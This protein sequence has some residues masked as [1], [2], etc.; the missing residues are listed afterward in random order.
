M[1][2]A[3]TS[4]TYPP[5]EAALA[6]LAFLRDELPLGG[7][8]AEARFLRLFPL[9]VS[10]IVGELNAADQYR[11]EPGGWLGRKERWSSYGSG[12]G[13]GA[14]RGST[15]RSP[16]GLRGSSVGGGIGGSSASGRPAGVSRTA[17]VASSVNGSGSGSGSAMSS[18]DN[19]PVVQLLTGKSGPGGPGGT[20]GSGPMGQTS[21][22]P[23]QPTLL[24]AIS[25]ESVHR[26]GVR[27]SFDFRALPRS[28]QMALVSLLLDAVPTTNVRP[29]AARLWGSVLRVPASE[30][31]DLRYALQRQLQ[32]AQQKLQQQH[33]G[34]G[35]VQRPGGFSP[36]G[37]ASPASSAPSG[38]AAM[39]AAAVL[40]LPA[41]ARAVLSLSM[42][43]YYLLY[44]VRFAASGQSSQAAAPPPASATNG[45]SSTPTSTV[46]GTPV[47]SRRSTST[48]GTRTPSTPSASSSTPY[49][50]GIS[51]V[52]RHSYSSRGPYGEQI[53]LHLFQS[54]AKRYL[55]HMQPMM[56][57][58][59][60]L[61]AA[62]AASSSSHGKRVPRPP[63]R[64]FADLERDAEFFHRLV[65]EIW[66]DGGAAGASAPRTA[67]A[68]KR[69][70]NSRGG[71]GVGSSPFG[72]PMT[73]STPLP[74]ASAVGLDMSS[75]LADLGWGS[76]AAYQEPS[77][78]V[79]RGTRL[80][81]NHI[82][83]DPA[84]GNAVGGEAAF[85][86][87]R[88]GVGNII[89][90]GSKAAGMPSPA[91]Q[92]RLDDA[93]G[94]CLT[95]AMTMAQTP[96]YN[97]VRMNL[98][99]SP[100]HV[101]NSAFFSAMNA[102]LVWLE[103]WNCSVRKNR[104]VTSNLASPT[105][106]KKFL[107]DTVQSLGGQSSKFDTYTSSIT[108]PKATAPSTYTSA[109]E[110]YIAANLYLY[111]VPLAIFLRR[112]RELDF[113]SNEFAKSLSHMQRVFR[114]FTPE[115][116]RVI[117][118]LLA[119][120]AGNNPL[121]EMVAQHERNLGAFCPPIGREGLSL[122]SCMQDMHNVLEEIFLQHQKKIREQDF[123]DSIEQ[124][125]EGL[126]GQG[127]RGDEVALE[128]LLA[129]ARVIASLPAD[130]VVL[131][132][133]KEGSKSGASSILF[134]AKE[135][136]YQPERVHGGLLTETGRQQI[137]TGARKCN[138]ME[139]AYLGDPMYSRIKS[140]EIPFLVTWAVW[141]SDWMNTRLDEAVPGLNVI[142]KH[143]SGEVLSPSDVSDTAALV[144]K[145]FQQGEDQKNVR[146][147]INLRPLAD[148]R[149]LICLTIWW[150]LGQFFTHK[151]LALFAAFIFSIST[152][153][154][155]ISS[156]F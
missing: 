72:M 77:S 85:T 109:W 106:A 58:Q 101:S 17:S 32:V 93:G 91:Q 155:K 25:D 139:V 84:I 152:A 82:V 74:G 24:D 98:R 73:P 59:N 57:P 105:K 143:E 1:E 49:N 13:S 129:Q 114:V 5:A 30:Q 141:A 28:T 19:D 132:G 35:A 121:S 20:S 37:G 115:V 11:H 103:P 107:T 81:V 122:S 154:K 135:N 138:A 23:R 130:Y 42:L 142:P 97:Y 36:L 68:M 75:E 26:P 125:L 150:K 31:A 22:M 45:T 90:L 48:S 52:N 133:D 60:L 123:L 88:R 108:I 134:S 34:G 78:L 43:E 119:R 62:A 33:R 144:L 66:L 151:N 110:P 41:D 15:G 99:H 4:P 71:G 67:D 7:T 50:L 51:G 12:A 29:N 2:E 27:F 64:S 53:Y 137:L 153:L 8:A 117:D 149:N 124:K 131:P 80:L 89:H 86:S 116:V 112:A 102:W 9:L 148:Y 146:F 156:L 16:G 145:H 38:G 55:P 10:R 95:P 147:R 3:L 136:E 39:T 92:A 87:Q 111:A 14:G 83:S 140:Y 6:L 70:S 18:P 65:L 104:P 113:S 47:T 120:E 61:S 100:V 46:A 79:R 63:V 118:R 44:F 96:F 40:P 56:P 127:T 128:K 54:Y 94:W 21:R 76:S 126:F 69:L